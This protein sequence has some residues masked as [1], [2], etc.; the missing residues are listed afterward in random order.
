VYDLDERLERLAAEATRDT[1]APELAAVARRGR[2]RRRRQLAGTAALVVAVAAAGL[3]LPARLAGRTPA[4]RPLPATAPATDVAGAARL[5]GY[6]FG[7]A[8]AS[9]FLEQGVA[10]A[11]R[12][13]IRQRLEAL[14][15]VDQVYY[16]SR[17][18]AYARFKV[19][20]QSRPELVRNTGPSVMPE[21]FRVR[22]VAPED[23]K[24][25]Q[26][27]LCPRPP[28]KP[29]GSWRC[30]DGVDSVIEERALVEGI[31]VPK[32]WPAASDVSVFLPP[33]GGDAQRKAVRA[34]LEAIDGVARVTYE[35]PQAVF[36]R[37]PEKVRMVARDS[38]SPVYTWSSVPAAFR[39]ALDRPSRVREFHVALCGSRTTGVCPGDLVVLEH[40]RR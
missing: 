28:T 15:V 16:E 4:W 7:R 29:V 10:P 12:S 23:F 27:S 26:R 22:L 8:D 33:G 30:M 24:Q 20:F 19:Q 35:S 5:G 25:L 36:R 18:D 37:L 14:G 34:R 39:V 32:P 40:P 17:L 1:V 2:R 9:V 38:A 6:W 11:Q 3:V 13:A 31:L 21:S